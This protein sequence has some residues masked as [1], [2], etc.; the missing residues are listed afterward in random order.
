M[1]EHL[2]GVRARRRARERRRPAAAG[3]PR[4]VRALAE[5]VAPVHVLVCRIRQPRCHWGARGAA[6][7][8]LRDLRGR[9]ARRHA[10]QARARRATAALGAGAQPVGG[11]DAAALQGHFRGEQ[12]EPAAGAHARRRR[13]S[14]V[15]RL[16][17]L[18][19]AHPFP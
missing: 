12:H 11:A 8:R 19:H 9:L 17:E 1:N 4:A 6:A 5:H 7:T 10:P 18:L 15:P 13:T 16:Q 2:A 14:A 3:G